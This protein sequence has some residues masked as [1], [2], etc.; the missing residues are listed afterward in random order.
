MIRIGEI[1]QMDDGSLC[2]VWTNGTPEPGTVLYASS[3]LADDWQAVIDYAA[4][5]LESDAAPAVRDDAAR[6]LRTLS[7]TI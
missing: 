6:S 4:S 7:A 2:P 1:I 5:V 3:S